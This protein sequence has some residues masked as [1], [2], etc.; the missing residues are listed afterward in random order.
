MRTQ[1]LHQGYTGALASCTNLTLSV[2][3]LRVPSYSAWIGF[4]W[5]GCSQGYV[6]PKALDTDYGEPLGFCKE[7]SPGVFERNW[8]KASV[9]MD[10][11]K[12]EG[13]IIPK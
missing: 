13:S 4:A 11:H 10:C 6:R 3:L 12:W 2:H 9:K 8:T 1:C 7:T 5:V